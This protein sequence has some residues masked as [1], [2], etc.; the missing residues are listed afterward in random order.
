MQLLHS[1]MLEYLIIKHI[2]LSTLAKTSMSDPRYKSYSF[3]CLEIKKWGS[4]Q[5]ISTVDVR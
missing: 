2:K 5:K 1:P 4:V 3:V